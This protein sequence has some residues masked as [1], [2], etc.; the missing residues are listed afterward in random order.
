M[1]TFSYSHPSEALSADT[2]SNLGSVNPFGTS[3]QAPLPDI[4][5]SLTLVLKGKHSDLLFM[6]LPHGKDLFLGKYGGE[7]AAGETHLFYGFKDPEKNDSYTSIFILLK[8]SKDKTLI[9]TRHLVE[10]VGRMCP[11]PGFRRALFKHSLKQIRHG[12]EPSAMTGPEENML[13]SDYDS[14]FN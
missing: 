6:K 10:N 14:D 12:I 11:F 13:R 9:V 1:P 8:T 5:D 4:D 7:K 2:Y 3:A